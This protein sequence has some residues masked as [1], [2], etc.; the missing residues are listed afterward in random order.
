MSGLRRR[1][2][3]A[4]LVVA[5]LVAPVAALHGAAAARLPVTAAPLQT[6]KVSDLPAPPGPD[7]PPVP[8]VDLGMCGDVDAYDEVVYGTEGDD[9]IDG[10]NGR[11]ILVGLGGDDVLRGENHNDCLV[12][13]D[14][15]DLLVGGNG[16]DLLFGQ[17]GADVL[18]GGT[19]KDLMDAGGDAGDSCVS[20]GAPDVLIGCGSS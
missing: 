19:G 18:E 4:A 17:Y 10:G 11:Q 7:E 14:G 6:W 16:R 1:V 13:G 8:S 12:G 9:E 2:P 20:D 5:V 3:I 15:D